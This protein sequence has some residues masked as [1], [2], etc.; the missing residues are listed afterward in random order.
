MMCTSC[1][2][3]NSFWNLK[4]STRAERTTASLSFSWL[5]KD[6]REVSYLQSGGMW[7]IAAVLLKL[8]FCGRSITHLWSL[9]V[10]IVMY[11]D[12]E[13][14]ILSVINCKSVITMPGDTTLNKYSTAW[15]LAH[16]FITDTVSLRGGF[17]TE[18]S[19]HINHFVIMHC[20][21]SPDMLTN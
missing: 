19:P 16:S 15:C 1:G 6:Y 7:W 9:S 20:M 11:S 17:Y 4:E 13:S 12:Q 10:T 5:L 18:V 8:L 2:G 3:G 14:E 21:Q